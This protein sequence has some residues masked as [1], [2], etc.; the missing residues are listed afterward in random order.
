MSQAFRDNE[1]RLTEEWEAKLGYKFAP[2]ESIGD[3]VIIPGDETDWL[4]YPVVQWIK[5]KIKH[6]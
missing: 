1:K 6:A 5:Q 4:F 2:G 3:Y